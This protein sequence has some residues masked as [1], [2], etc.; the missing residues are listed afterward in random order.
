[1]HVPGGQGRR[2]IDRA[3]REVAAQH[4]QVV[5]VKDDRRALTY[6][7]LD[8]VSNQVAVALCERVAPRRGVALVAHTSTDTAVAL[9][10]AAKAG[11]VVVAVD[12]REPASRF[13]E[14]Y[15]RGRC[16][17]LLASG[18][19]RAA[20]F[21]VLDLPATIERGGATE[22]P[23][24]EI[25][26]DDIAG[27]FFTS[28]STGQPKGIAITHGNVVNRSTLGTEIYADLLVGARS[29]PLSPL[30]FGCAGSLYALLLQRSTAY[31]LDVQRLGIKGTAGWLC[32]EQM[33]LVLT[34][35]VVLRQ[36]SEAVLAEHGPLDSVSLVTV[37]GEAL[38][39]TDAELCFRA[40]P[41][42]QVRHS[43]GTSETGTIAAGALD[44]AVRPSG[45]EPVGSVL[46]WNMVEVVD[47]H[48]RPVPPGAIGEIVVSSPSVAR[49]YW[50]DDA[51]T[52]ERF[53]DTPD[54]TRRF[55]TGDFGR[56]TADG[57]L[58]LAGRGDDQVKVR[59]QRVDLGLVTSALIG[60][61]G[62]DDAVVLADEGHLT[63]YLVGSHE[64]TATALSES[65]ATRLPSYMIPAEFHAVDALPRTERGKVDRSALRAMTASPLLTRPEFVA[66]RTDVEARVA[67]MFEE[68]LESAD[69]GVDDDFAELGGDSLGMLELLEMIQDEFAIDLHGYLM[70][71]STAHSAPTVRELARAIAAARDSTRGVDEHDVG[72]RVTL[73]DDGVTILRIGEDAG[74]PTLFLV[75]GA[76][77]STVRFVPLAASLQH[78]TTYTFHQRG[79]HTRARPDRRV[80]DIAARFVTAARSVQPDGPYRIGGFSFGAR[81]AYDMAQELRAQGEEVAVLVLIDPVVTSVAQQSRTSARK[82]SGVRSRVARYVLA[83]PWRSVPEA[84]RYARARGSMVA[85]RMGRMSSSRAVRARQLRHLAVG[86]LSWGGARP[87]DGATLVVRSDEAASVDDDSADGPQLSGAVEVIHVP[88][89]HLR[90]LMRPCVLDVAARIDALGE[91]T[92]RERATVSRDG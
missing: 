4:P 51:L 54:G 73:R 12:P 63:A 5:A 65:L 41:N 76:G 68:L 39:S 59:G 43:Y 91:R 50:A 69:V 34:P 6:G 35:P 10:G 67:A 14:L 60:A 70:V 74:H 28:G 16:E 77:D 87:Y 75:A 42:A 83:P 21:P 79:Y 1:V 18:A 46:P 45:L 27:V 19:E 71:E 84:Y 81:I 49:G 32:R 92:S 53:S 38:G 29:A 24:V 2:T 55:R 85:A 58:A 90:V 31:L 37:G 61:P 36:L 30:A 89:T 20:P 8:A 47:D 11:V 80:Q 17:L 88:T 15:E 57:M 66:P 56:L 44:P 22:G 82:R 3:L 26:K 40:F 64:L 52:A 86:M 7:E 9:V 78:F 72:G 33:Q 48:G 23:T 25:D 13:A 62:V